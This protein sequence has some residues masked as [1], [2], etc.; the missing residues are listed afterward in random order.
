[1]KHFDEQAK[2]WDANPLKN[3]R[4]SVVAKEI[5]EFIHPNK[6]LNALEFGCGT[7]LLSFQLKEAFKSITLADN[8]EGM[9]QVL[10]E[11]IKESRLSHFKPLHID[12][13]TDKLESK[14]YDVVYTLMTMHHIP[15]T[16]HI[17]KAFRDIL[18]P[19]GYL[20]IADL[21][22]EDG[23][24][25]AHQQHF[26]GHNGFNKNAFADQLSKYGFEV[27]Y[28]KICFEMERN[29]DGNIRKYPL[30]LMIC[31]KSAE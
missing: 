3:E 22:E 19:D 11:K 7:G 21:V 10:Q 28:Y 29:F 16:D 26:N 8:S 24:F 30:F 17:L 13:T 4:A 15:D 1:M 20:C 2:D 23:S 27:V 6:T 14:A 31:K 5:D 25:H 9:I 18:K 12:L